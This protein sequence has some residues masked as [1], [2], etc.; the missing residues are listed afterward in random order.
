MAGGRE[1]EVRNE[2]AKQAVSSYFT[3]NFVFLS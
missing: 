2:K 1:R 3:K